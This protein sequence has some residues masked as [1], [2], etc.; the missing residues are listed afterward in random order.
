MP[1]FYLILP[2]FCLIVPKSNFIFGRLHADLE[3]ENLYLYS[4]KYYSQLTHN[5]PSDGPGASFAS[6][7]YWSQSHKSVD[8]TRRFGAAW[9]QFWLQ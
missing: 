3:L 4:L 5:L 6:A 9:Q 8:A 7:R 2:N 1:K